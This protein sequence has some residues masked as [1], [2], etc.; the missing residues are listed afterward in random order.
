MKA[1]TVTAH[2]RFAKE[3]L[4]TLQDHLAPA[5]VTFR[6][7]HLAGDA[8]EYSD[9]DLHA[10]VSRRL[11]DEFFDSLAAR[12]EER[13][14]RLSVRYDPEYK[15][16]TRV[17]YL[18]ITLHEFPIFWRLD[19]IVTSDCESPRKYP[20]PFPDWS[21]TTSA[22]WN[23]VW[24]V[25]YCKRGNPEA[26]DHYA[27]S[28]CDKLRIGRVGYSDDAVKALLVRLANAGDV[29][30]ELIARLR[31]ELLAEPSWDSRR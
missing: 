25:K 14:G 13:F 4:R 22:F 30:G 8:D 10:R 23:L 11:D 18:T 29:D 20:D 1:P 19:L 12:L 15:D 24:A 28:A 6:G 16:D 3:V 9:V 2:Q 31:D 27:A 26:A 5:E 17:Q 21:A 7:S